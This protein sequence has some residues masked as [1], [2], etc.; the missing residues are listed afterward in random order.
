MVGFRGG[1]LAARAPFWLLCSTARMYEVPRAEGTQGVTAWGR[2]LRLVF[3]FL[4]QYRYHGYHRE[5]PGATGRFTS[6]TKK[7]RNVDGG[8]R[9]VGSFVL[10][11]E[12]RPADGL[13]PKVYAHLTLDL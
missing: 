5:I 12:T 4:R 3:P 13:V 7:V 11:L 6:G 2:L 10:Q 1:W 8:D 9:G